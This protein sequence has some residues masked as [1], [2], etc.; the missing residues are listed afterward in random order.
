MLPF[1]DRQVACEVLRD[2][3]FDGLDFVVIDV[4]DPLALEWAPQAAAA[5]AR[6]WSTSPERSGWSPTCRS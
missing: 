5:G 1:A 2:G 3:C 4:D 6:V